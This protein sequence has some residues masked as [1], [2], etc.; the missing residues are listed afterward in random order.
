MRLQR[1]RW[2]PPAAA[3]RLRRCRRCRPAPRRHTSSL[4]RPSRRG[5]GIASRR[6][7]TAHCLLEYWVSCTHPHH[8]R[9]RA[10]LLTTPAA[11]HVSWQE[12]SWRSE[13]SRVYR[14]RSRSPRTLPDGDDRK[15]KLIAVRHA[16]T[17]Y[18]ISPRS[19]LASGSTV[20]HTVRFCWPSASVRP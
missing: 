12:L 20:V 1:S 11:Q 10:V 19:V 18:I 3:E 13:G 5:A 17:S 4:K 6:T 2:P 8:S 16:L 9:L 7:I 15:G 14:R